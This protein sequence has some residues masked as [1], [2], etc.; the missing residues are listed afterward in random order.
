MMKILATGDIHYD[1]IR[2][3]TE[4]ENFLRFIESVR[5]EAPDV[6]ILVGDTVG[7]DSTKLEECLDIF[8][9][10]A[11]VRL[12]VLGNHEH[13][14]YEGDTFAHL[15]EMKNRVKACGFRLLDDRPEIVDGI[16]FAGNCGWYDY[17]LAQTE[18]PPYSSYER[19]I[20][21]G[22]I[23][24]ND[25]HFVRLGKTDQN[26]SDELLERLETDIKLLESEAAHI[27]AVTHH[28]GFTEML[29]SWENF[30]GL[31]FCSAYMG[32]R[33]LGEML[34]RHPKVGYHIC[35]HTHIR[36]ELR[37]GSLTSINPGS[38]YDEKRFDSITI[39]HG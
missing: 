28:I 26:Y 14:S 31:N 10:V 20:F 9:S 3:D 19:K 13:W 21:G 6:L 1:L 25:F 22:H 23:I 7:L 33:K 8:S 5:R 24:W 18:P 27:V 30:P 34:L 39:R 32:S 11:P 2:T 38:T 17:S 12:M 37:K 35:G 29:T 15:E 16:G 36:Q 4:H